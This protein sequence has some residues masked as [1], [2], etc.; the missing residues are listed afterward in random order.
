MGGG[1]GST[2]SYLETATEAIAQLRILT[3]RCAAPR[4]IGAAG[5]VHAIEGQQWNQNLIREEAN[6]YTDEVCGTCREL[7]EKIKGPEGGVVAG[8]GGGV[9]IP[10]SVQLLIWTEVTQSVMGALLEGFARVE[11][12]STEG[13]SLMSMDLQAVQGGLDDIQKVRPIRGKVHVDNYVK[14]FY[15]GEADVMAWI[16][17]NHQ[18][19]FF[20]HMAGL[21]NAGVG[22]KKKRGLRELII[23]VASLYAPEEEEEQ[24]GRKEGEDRGAV[25]GAGKEGGRRGGATITSSLFGNMHI[26]SASSSSTGSS[27]AA[28]PTT[29]SASSSASSSAAHAKT[30][31]SNT[32][33]NMMQGKGLGKGFL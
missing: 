22:Q 17:Q 10:P 23:K 2:E 31:I 8:M 18:S 30:S 24:E 28:R 15:Y 9:Y 16:E 21:L 13:R 4:L 6:P 1:R 25:H 7:W 12:C 14:A 5:L 3:Y 20:R 33:S 11:R 29:T 27:S 19:Y 26:S 32:F